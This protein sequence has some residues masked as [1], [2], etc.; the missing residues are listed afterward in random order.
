[1]GLTQRSAPLVG[2]HYLP[3]VYL[4]PRVMIFLPNETLYHLEVLL[5][6]PSRSALMLMVY[7]RKCLPRDPNMDHFYNE[8][9]NHFLEL[10]MDQFWLLV[11]F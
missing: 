2:V 4:M 8:N 10:G 11:L 9:S 6:R 7:E 3:S 5:I 1:M